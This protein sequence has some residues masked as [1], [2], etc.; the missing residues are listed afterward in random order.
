MTVF[1]AQLRRESHVGYPRFRSLGMRFSSFSFATLSF[2]I[3]FSFDDGFIGLTM[4][5]SSVVFADKR[6]VVPR[7]NLVNVADLNRDLRSK[8]FVSED[9]FLRAVHLILDFEP[10]SDTFQEV[11]HAIKAGDLRLRR[12]DVFVP[13]FLARRTSRP[14]S[15]HPLLPSLKQRF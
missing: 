7:L 12:I 1:T 14:S 8:V 6:H 13:G 15:C 2:N 10:I 9:R 11:G 5:F 4:I 3:L